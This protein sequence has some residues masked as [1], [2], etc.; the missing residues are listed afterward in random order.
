M[1]TSILVKISLIYNLFL[2]ILPFSN[3][4]IIK[5]QGDSFIYNLI[6][7]CL[8]IRFD[9]FYYCIICIFLFSST[10]FSHSFFS[11]IRYN[12]S[13]SSIKCH[14]YH[15]VGGKRHIPVVCNESKEPHTSHYPSRP[16]SKK[17]TNKL[18]TPATIPVEL[19]VLSIHALYIHLYMCVKMYI[20]I[21][22]TDSNLLSLKK[23]I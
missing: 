3:Y 16:V 10:Y 22:N 20:H 18:L 23:Y 7:L 11:T 14:G 4:S 6:V 17:T 19:Y 12:G 8:F 5:C 9:V 13:S 15:H 1:M 21:S 2:K